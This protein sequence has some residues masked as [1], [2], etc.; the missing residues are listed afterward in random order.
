MSLHSL[1][2]KNR[3]RIFLVTY[4]FLISLTFCYIY[5]QK[6]S[7]HADFYSYDNSA[8]IYPVTEFIALKG[9]QYR[10]LIPFTF[11]AIWFVTRLP[12]KA[13]YF[14]LIIAQTLIIIFIFYRLLNQIFEDRIKNAVIAPIIAYPMAWNYIIL[15]QQI[16]FVDY[17]N[18]LF[19]LLAYLL[20]IRNK[21][22]LLLVTFIFACLNHDSSGF[23]PLMYLFYNYKKIFTKPVMLNL[24]LLGFMYVGIKLIL[25]QVFINNEGPSFRWNYVRNFY[26][27]EYMP[28]HRIVRN[29]VL[30]YGGLH[31]FV[32]LGLKNPI[33]KTINKQLIAINL[34]F[35]PYVLVIF[36]IHSIEE[37][38]NYIASIPFIIIPFL[39]YV[40]SIEG[41]FL[42]LKV[43]TSLPEGISASQR[44]EVV[45]DR[46]AGRPAS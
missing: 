19:I 25:S 4:Y 9:L 20:I 37:I 10:L 38:R 44:P 28:I 36:L 23:I 46:H 35:F 40:S 17:S 26:Y 14:I 29:I 13:V 24:F 27:A 41:N 11:K 3:R 30:I 43:K 34:V 1:I 45:G 31:I 16:F 7:N 15:N 33:W 42:K 5:H 6:L 39:I 22:K 12:D 2:D 8:G 32:A 18:L 21:N